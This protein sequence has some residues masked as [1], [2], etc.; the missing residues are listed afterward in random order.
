MYAPP[1]SYPE[2]LKVVYLSAFHV[3]C[4]LTLRVI[5]TTA[6][7]LTLLLTS[8]PKPIV[9][10]V[11]EA[12]V[13]RN[14]PVDLYEKDYHYPPPPQLVAPRLDEPLQRPHVQSA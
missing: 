6:Y 2:A 5:G 8:V 14:V 10:L 1:P 3:A 13:V 9:P 7:Q 4:E 11:S 12:C